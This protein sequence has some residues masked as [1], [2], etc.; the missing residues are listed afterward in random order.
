MCA[1]LEIHVSYS[2]AIATQLIGLE[3]I[4]LLDHDSSML[5]REIGMYAVHSNALLEIGIKY[6]ARYYSHN[7]FNI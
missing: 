3:N 5:C 2:L 6:E 4:T 7:L 1:F